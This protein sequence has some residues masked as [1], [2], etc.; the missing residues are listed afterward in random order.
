MPARCTLATVDDVTRLLDAALGQP[1]QVIDRT[2]TAGLVVSTV[3]TTDDQGYETAIL[4]AEGAW[5][6]ARYE[7]VELAQT[8]H[9]EW[10]ARAP[11]LETITRLGYGD[12]IDDEPHALKR[13]H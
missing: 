6:V 10:V 5:P 1:G 11:Q 13:R 8:G 12:V 3:L 9:N 2:D 7:T 4:D